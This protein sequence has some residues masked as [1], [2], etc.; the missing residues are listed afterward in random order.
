MPLQSFSSA[1]RR[2]SIRL[3]NGKLR[4][5]GQPTEGATIPGP[6]EDVWDDA[7]PGRRLTRL[8]AV[9]P[10]MCCLGGGQADANAAT[11]CAP[12][13]N[14]S[15]SWSYHPHLRSVVRDGGDGMAARGGSP[16]EVVA[17][18]AEGV[19]S[20]REDEARLRRSLIRGRRKRH[21]MVETNTDLE[22]DASAPVAGA[23]L[24]LACHDLPPNPR[25]VSLAL[26]DVSNFL[27]CPPDD[28]EDLNAP[29]GLQTP[30]TAM[31]DAYGWEGDTGKK[32]TL[33]QSSSYVS[34]EAS[35]TKTPK[36]KRWIRRATGQWAP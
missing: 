2:W 30:A 12:A 18:A 10:P 33:E 7:H 22:G 13:R 28:D 34:S 26:T 15:M 11:D 29:I 23:R 9:R 19:V 24:R 14:V 31:E 1:A 20:G 36:A 27:G 4:L 6:K 8:S 5:R 3:R 32:A 35:R 21:S 25:C 16:F 17:S